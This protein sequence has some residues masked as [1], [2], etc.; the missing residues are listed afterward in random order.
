MD[1]IDLKLLIVFDEVYKAHSISLAAENLGLGQPAVS[2]SLNK[3]RSHFKDPLFVRTSSGMEPTPHADEL[4]YLVREAIDLLRLT[5]G[6]QAVFDAKTSSRTF[7]IAMTDVG[8]SIVIPALLEKLREVA[9]NVRITHI[10]L[11]KDTP[12]QLESAE[13]DLAVGFL[14]KMGPG[15]FQRQIFKEWYVCLICARHPRIKDKLSLAQFKKERHI[16][17]TVKGSGH[18]AIDRTLAD[19]NVERPVGIRI[20]NF[21]GIPTTIENS[22]YLAMVPNRFGLVLARSGRFKILKLPFNVPVFSIMEHWHA[23]LSHDPG[24]KWLR[25]LLISVFRD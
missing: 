12:R 11:S 25:E 13:A 10:E 4:I 9:P 21:L 24:I 17:V 3:F 19:L 16:I 18:S 1:N 14:P 7:N 5:L 22:D 2:M 8:A 20:P 23:R 15:F 6:H